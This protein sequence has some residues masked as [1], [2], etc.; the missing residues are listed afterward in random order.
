MFR[1]TKQ[2]IYTDIN[3]T[4]CHWV[5]KWVKLDGIFVFVVQYE[6]EVFFFYSLKW[7]KRE[8][9]KLTT[10][11]K[12]AFICISFKYIYLFSLIISLDMCEFGLWTV[13]NIYI[14]YF[15]RS[16]IELYLYPNEEALWIWKKIKNKNK[17]TIM[18]LKW[19]EM[20]V[21][22][23]VYNFIS[24]QKWHFLLSYSSKLI[25]ILS[26]CYHIFHDC[27]VIKIAF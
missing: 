23:A 22:F 11:I 14:L 8:C 1:I 17:K 2:A 18:N 6:R 7:S 10:H 4:D 20:C 25:L 13:E 3:Y 16:L 27:A 26:T 12:S 5:S 19:L 9:H 24:I 21:E 15:V